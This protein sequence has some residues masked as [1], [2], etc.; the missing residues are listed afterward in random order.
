LLQVL[1]KIATKTLTSR[2]DPIVHKL[3]D[4]YQNAF[5]KGRYIFEGVMLLQEILRETKFRKQQWVVLKIDF[6]QAYDNVNWDF[7]FD[8]CRHM[9]FSDS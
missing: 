1:F 8:C 3:I 2:V 9:G 6:E 4:Y 5:I 7:L